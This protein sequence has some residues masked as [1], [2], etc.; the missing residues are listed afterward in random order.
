[1]WCFLSS[2]PHTLSRPFTSFS[3]AANQKNR[4]SMST[5]E[6]AQD[7][8]HDNNDGTSAQLRLHLFLVVVGLLLFIGLLG[9]G[10]LHSV[11]LLLQG[12]GLLRLGGRGLRRLLLGGGGGLGLL[13]LGRDA[14]LDQ[15][16]D[17]GRSDQ[18]AVHVG[19][20]VPRGLGLDEGATSLGRVADGDLLLQLPCDFVQQALQCNSSMSSSHTH[21]HTCHGRR[22][23]PHAQ[24]SAWWWCRRL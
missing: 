1:L 18:V 21:T 24:R 14:G 15:R 9:Q 8:R 4:T 10:E 13:G 12:E 6:T 5:C 19:L 22:D 20:L 23:I 7:Q 17:L 11:E 16:V 2:P 3:R